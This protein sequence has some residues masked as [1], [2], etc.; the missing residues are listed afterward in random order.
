VI[1]NLIMIGFTAIVVLLVWSGVCQVAAERFRRR[2]EREHDLGYAYE[3]LGEG[4]ENPT[5]RKVWFESATAYFTRGSCYMDQAQAWRQRD[6]LARIADQLMTR[7]KKE[8]L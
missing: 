3:M 8:A 1:A 6:A 5:S 7:F 4:T 2:A